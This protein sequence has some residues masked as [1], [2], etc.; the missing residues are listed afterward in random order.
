MHTSWSKENPP[1]G[2]F[3]I[4]YVPWSRAV[5]KR[6]HDGMLCFAATELKSKPP[7]GACL[8]KLKCVLL[9]FIN[10]TLEIITVPGF[11]RVNK[12][13]IIT[14]GGQILTLHLFYF[15]CSTGPLLFLCELFVF[16]WVWNPQ[17]SAPITSETYTDGG[18]IN[19]VAWKRLARRHSR[20]VPWNE[21]HT[22]THV[23]KQK[24]HRTSRNT[25]HGR[26]TH[27]WKCWLFLFYFITYFFSVLPFS[28]TDLQL[29]TVSEKE[30]S[31]WWSPFQ[32][33]HRHCWR[34]RVDIASC[35][36]CNSRSEVGV[37][38]VGVG[39]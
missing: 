6:F 5:C 12:R 14:W 35:F 27:M 25:E 13:Q 21:W 11:P 31:F 2:G 28:Y 3:S 26:R 9:C 32:S 18:A 10:L 7:R 19:K 8:I 22:N 1:P 15:A 34:R 16:V 17:A 36:V 38:T 20:N 30:N 24:R 37:W 33:S 23:F 39:T 29:V 4:Y